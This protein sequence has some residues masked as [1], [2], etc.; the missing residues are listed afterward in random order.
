MTN[1]SVSFFFF[2]PE[3]K[4]GKYVDFSLSIFVSA[5]LQASVA[6]SYSSSSCSG[7]NPAELAGSYGLAGVNV[8]TTIVLVGKDLVL[9]FRLGYSKMEPLR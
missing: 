2:S 1:I 9:P 4:I 5:P 3:G 8:G 7:S 6:L